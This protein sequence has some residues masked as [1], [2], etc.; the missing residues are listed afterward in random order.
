MKIKITRVLSAMVCALLVALSA[1]QAV[2]KPKPAPQ[3]PLN[4]RGQALLDRYEAMLNGLQGQI[5]DAVPTVDQKSREAYRAA[6]LAEAKAEKD[7]ASAKSALGEIGKAHG[8]VGHA[9]NYWIPKAKKNIAA[10]QAKLKN[11]KTPAEREAAQ[12]ELDKWE[13][14][15]KNGN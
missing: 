9:R 1:Q 10:A 13:Q 8:L 6:R 4:E 12:K 14:D 5:A 3:A 7:L 2:A 11:A 15:L